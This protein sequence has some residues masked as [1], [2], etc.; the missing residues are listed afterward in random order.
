MSS[1][2][3]MSQLHDLFDLDAGNLLLTGLPAERTQ[4]QWADALAYDPRRSWKRPFRRVS[5]SHA[6]VIETLFVPTVQS[7]QIACTL[8]TMLVASLRRRDPRL[9]ENRRAIFE[10]GEWRRGRLGRELEDLPWFGVSASGSILAGPTGCAKTHTIKGLARLLPQVIE[11]GEA[12]DCGWLFLKQLVYLHVDMPADAGRLGLLYGLV[13]AVDTALG[14]T[15]AEDVLKRRTIEEKLVE[16]LHILMIHRCGMLILDEVQVRNVKPAVLG[17]EFVTFFLR[18]LNCGIPLVLIGNPLAFEHVLDF[19]QDLRR[20]T[21]A[22]HFECGP[23][24]DP[25]DA[26]WDEIIVPSVWGWTVFNNQD[27]PVRDLGNLLFERTGGILDVLVKYRRECLVEALRCGASCVERIHLDAVYRRSPV[28]RPLHRL[29]GAYAKRDLS[30]L[31]GFTDQPVA[32]LEA[33][34]HERES[35]RRAI[36]QESSTPGARLADSKAQRRTR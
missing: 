4:E 11:H 19:S 17:P 33:Y 29:V 1:R 14:T 28:M 34:W 6:H 10:F 3:A 2:R 16:V 7:V 5:E 8:F 15:Y 20:L 26:E 27:E 23:I 21:A 18:V 12:P 35:M 9:A 36:R 30:T 25:S 31:A 32:F 24:D 13:K 22:G